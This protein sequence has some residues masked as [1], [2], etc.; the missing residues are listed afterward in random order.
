MDLIKGITIPFL[1]YMENEV[2]SGF[3]NINKIEIANSLHGQQYQ[4]DSKIVKYTIVPTFSLQIKVW[5][6][7]VYYSSYINKVTRI[8]ELSVDDHVNKW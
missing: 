7:A 8:V 3:I 1:C 2:F 5:L 4:S 6:K